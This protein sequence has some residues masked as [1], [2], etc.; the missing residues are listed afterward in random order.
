[1][2]TGA[3]PGLRRP[4]P[5]QA[6]LPQPHRLDRHRRPHRGDDALGPARA[7][8]RRRLAGA[9]AAPREARRPRVLG[10]GAVT[11]SRAAPGV[12]PGVL[13]RGARDLR[14]HR[15]DV[16]LRPDD[17]G[18]GRLG[19][20]RG[21]GGGGPRADRRRR[22]RAAAHGLGAQARPAGLCRG[23]RAGRGSS[24]PTPASARS[25]PRASS[26][27][28]SWCCR[29]GPHL[30]EHTSDH[31]VETVGWLR[32]RPGVHVADDEG[33]SPGCIAAAAAAAAAG[34]RMA[35]TADPAFIARL[36]RFIE[37]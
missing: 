34:A 1:M 28:R 20:G 30:G 12:H 8:L 31:Q 36:R 24:S 27:G 23:D 6:P 16:P 15:L 3:A 5:R 25:S 29:G 26:A 35:R 33:D 22:L 9:V 32:G 17:P 18:D 19:R 37:G 14:H 11:G 21:A 4:R 7:A 2:T 13:R 10:G